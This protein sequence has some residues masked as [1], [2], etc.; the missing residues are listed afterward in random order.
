MKKILHQ[1]GIGLAATQVNWAVKLFMLAIDNSEKQLV[2][3]QIFLNPRILSYSKEQISMTEGCLSF[4]GLYIKIKRP[5]TIQWEF[6]NLEGDKFQI[7]ST[8]LYGRAV[9]HEIDHL[10][11]KVFINYASSVVIGSCM[12][13][14]LI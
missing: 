8:G 3:P 14:M 6:S 2:D 13:C 12:F 10:N 11:G 1:D 5:R 4:P 9:Q 7:E